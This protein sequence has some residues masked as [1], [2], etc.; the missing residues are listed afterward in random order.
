MNAY[1]R[2]MRIDR[3]IGTL[4]LLWPTLWA[5]WLANS[6][7]PELKT[8][9]IFILGTFVMRS[10][11]CVMNDIADRN[12]DGKVKRTSN[13]PLA[14]G[15]LSLQQAVITFVGLLTIAFILLL[16]LTISP[17]IVAAMG[18]IIAIAYPFCKRFMQA[19]QAILGFAFSWGIPMAYLCSQMP[20]THTTI[21]L[22]VIN[23]LWILCY[24][25][26]YALVDRDDDLKIGIHSTAILLGSHTKLMIGVLQI[27]IA[28]LWLLLAAINHFSY[29]FYIG[30][31]IGHSFFVYQYVLTKD[32]TRENCFA[33]FL[34]NNWYGLT[35]FMT[36]FVMYF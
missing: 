10:A 19:P 3:S 6:G 24:D 7:F 8:L 31:L 4:L 15:E 26:Y 25:T 5:L 34:N 1:F 27:I 2:L 35:L 28:G 20:I 12:F 21:L 30:W 18:A 9:I 29:I 22:F 11:G 33:A 36:F 17:I 13:R 14:N 32:L 16:Q 23:F